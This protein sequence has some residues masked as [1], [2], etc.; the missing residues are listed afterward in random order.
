MASED[1]GSLNGNRSTALRPNGPPIVI[2]GVAIGA[3]AGVAR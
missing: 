1:L 3:D 2:G